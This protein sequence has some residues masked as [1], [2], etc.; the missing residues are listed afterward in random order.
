MHKN[1]IEKSLSCCSNIFCDYF[2]VAILCD[3]VKT[4]KTDGFQLKT[5][6]FND[7][8]NFN[9]KPTAHLLENCGI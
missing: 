3:P 9:A 8:S 2:H 5:G 4:M 6:T 7:Q 1:S